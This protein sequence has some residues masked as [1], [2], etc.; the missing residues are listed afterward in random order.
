MSILCLIWL[1]TPTSCWVTWISPRGLTKC[2]LFYLILLLNLLYYWMVGKPTLCTFCRMIA[3]VYSQSIILFTRTVDYNRLTVTALMWIYSFMQ[4][5]KQTVG[6]TS[7]GQTYL[8]RKSCWRHWKNT[9]HKILITSVNNNSLCSA[10]LISPVINKT[11]FG[12]SI[13]FP[14]THITQATGVNS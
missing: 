12:N 3:N 5:N 4:I 8:S 9:K 11:L 10:L 6:H 14:N 7:S 1:L 13:M 2:I